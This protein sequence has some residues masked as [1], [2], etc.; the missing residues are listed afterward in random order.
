MATI[1]RE[2]EE[3]KARVDRLEAMVRRL[4]HDDEQ[5]SR[6]FSAAPPDRE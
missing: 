6:P 1:E 2:L 5:P 4:A 3:L